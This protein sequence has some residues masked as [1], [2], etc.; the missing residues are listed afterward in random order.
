MYLVFSTNDVVFKLVPKFFLNTANVPAFIKLVPW[1][2]DPFDSQVLSSISS[3]VSFNEE[4]YLLI[5]ISV[6]RYPVTDI[7]GMSQVEV[8]YGPFLGGRLTP[9]T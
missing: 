4:I 1:I 6:L 9:I 3:K 2:L 8:R 5:P 7:Q